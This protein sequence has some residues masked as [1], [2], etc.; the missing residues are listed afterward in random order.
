MKIE[1]NVR[2]DCGSCGDDSKMQP[3][4]LQQIAF[5]SLK[6]KV[7]PSQCTHRTFSVSH[8]GNRLLAR[9]ACLCSLSLCVLVVFGE[10]PISYCQML[11]VA[12]LFA[13]ICCFRLS[14][15]HDAILVVVG[16]PIDKSNSFHISAMSCRQ[17]STTSLLIVLDPCSSN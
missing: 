7:R 1:S 12:P 14:E 3:Q 6:V 4:F 15:P 2:R 8:I 5:K 9:R 17:H 10:L 16:A 11:G 13:P